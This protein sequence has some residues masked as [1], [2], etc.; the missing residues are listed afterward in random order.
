[1]S[2]YEDGMKVRRSVLGDKHVDNA[3]SQK[4]DF[5]TAFQNMI[6]ETAW[7]TVW[8]S[9]HLSKRERSMITLAILASLGHDEEVA[10]HIRSTKNTGATMQDIAEVMQHVA[11]YAGLPAA[12]TAIKIAKKVYEED[13]HD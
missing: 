11:I 4:T 13:N 3:Q 10:M 8:Q 6:T 9:D 5:D 1:M 12:N 2:K 7:G